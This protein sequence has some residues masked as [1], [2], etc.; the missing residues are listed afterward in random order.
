VSDPLAVTPDGL[1][2]AGDHLGA[3]SANLKKALTSLNTNLDGEG[4]A[5]GDDKGGSGFA[6]GSGGYVAQMNWV[7]G[8]VDAKTGLLDQYSET[9]RNTADTLEGQDKG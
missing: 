7:D 6:D 3:V 8:S 2:A 9:M 5:W 4:T 1:R